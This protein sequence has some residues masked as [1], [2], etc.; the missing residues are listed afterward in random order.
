[1]WAMLAES[2]D[3]ENIIE[4]VAALDIGK[5]ELVCCVRIP[6]PEG[7]QRGCRR[8]PRTRRCRGH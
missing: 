3:E 4:R 2:N 8:F 7:R 5:A 1:M 6:A